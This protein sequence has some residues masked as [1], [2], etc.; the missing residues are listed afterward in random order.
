MPRIAALLFL[1]LTSFTSGLRGQSTNASITGR[2]TDPSRATIPEAKVAAVNLGTR[3][4]A[5]FT[6]EVLVLGLPDA[7]GEVVLLSPDH[8]VSLGGQVY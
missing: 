3:T 4:I 7:D 2:V 8:E 1:F 6:S 5:G